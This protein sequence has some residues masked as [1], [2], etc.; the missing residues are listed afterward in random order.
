MNAYEKYMR[1]GDTPALSASIA[2][3]LLSQSPYHAWCAHPALNPDYKSVE[4]DEFDY[5]K[6]AHALFLERTEDGLMVVEADDWR[7]KAARE[8]RDAARSS[9]KTPI[10]ARQLGKVRDMVRAADEFMART[11]YPELMK[12]GKAE[13]PCEIEVDGVLLRCKVD[14]LPTATYADCPVLDFKST[15]DASPEAFGRLIPRLGYDIQARMY[16]LITGRPKFVF[17]AQE[18]EPPHACSLHAL[19]PT[20][21]EIADLKIERAIRIWKRCLATNEWPAYETQVHF[22]DA[23]AYE[24]TQHEQ[25]L[26]EEQ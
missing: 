20:M 8:M 6:A 4:K 12:R 13:V 10:L 7:T 22:H 2:K 17:L 21:E 19:A 25:R 15:T 16:Q 11:P 9:G 26:Q 3:I 24:M 18:D 23:T 14:W 5:G 1:E